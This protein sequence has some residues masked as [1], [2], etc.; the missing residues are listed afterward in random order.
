MKR[1]FSLWWILADLIRLTLKSTDLQIRR[2]AYSYFL[3]GVDS[4]V[5][6][7]RR[8]TGVASFLFVIPK[9]EQVASFLF[10]IP[11]GNLRFARISKTTSGGEPL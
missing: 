11:E 10:V 7:S 2:S 5:C 3:S 6:H 1:G 9:E 8:G 4:F